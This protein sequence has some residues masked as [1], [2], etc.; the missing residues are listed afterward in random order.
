MTNAE[1]Y[2]KDEDMMFELGTKLKEF[3]TENGKGLNLNTSAIYDFFGQEVKPTL[4][5]DEKVILRNIKNKY[6]N[7]GR[8]DFEGLHLFYDTE[9]H[10][11]AVKFNRYEK[12]F[13]FIQP[14]R[15]I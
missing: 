9:E 12:L 11:V 10:R 7:I 14:R 15:R 1:K 4:T 3:I 13:Q 6:T 5:E 2:L 8:F